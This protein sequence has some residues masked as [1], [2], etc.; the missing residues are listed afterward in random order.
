LFGAAVTLVVRKHGPM[1]YAKQS[2]PLRYVWGSRSGVM[3]GY[4]PEVNKLLESALDLLPDVQ[5][6]PEDELHKAF[7]ND[8]WTLVDV[9]PDIRALVSK[10]TRA[11]IRCAGL[12]KESNV[13]LLLRVDLAHD[14][15]NYRV[16][17]SHDGVALKEVPVYQADSMLI[18]A[19]VHVTDPKTEIVAEFL[20]LASEMPASNA[21]FALAAARA[22]ALE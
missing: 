13:T 9:A 3:I 15:E 21:Y 1:M 16:R 17:I 12:K 7:P 10:G 6:A 5:T 11:T 20:Q 22:C 19:S 18:Q 4:P 2:R 14:G 8:E